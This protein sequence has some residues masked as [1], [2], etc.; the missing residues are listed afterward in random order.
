MFMQDVTRFAA[1]PVTAAAMLG[2]GLIDG[3]LI[4]TAAG[5]RPVQSLRVGDSLQT[6]DGG[7]RRVVALNRREVLPG[8]PVVHLS[9]GHFDACS[10]VM[11]MPGQ[12]V[13]LDTVGLM[14]A[15]YARIAAA[16]LTACVGASTATAP[17]RVE[18]VTPIFAEEEVVWA[19]SGLLL[20]CPGLRG[21]DTA[22]PEL[23]ARA[24]TLFLAERSRRFA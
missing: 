19:Q 2:Q 8:E 24:A 6:L 9:G 12:S 14:A 4:E 10:D 21:G 18:V 22:F 15:P 5:W 16:A 11:L 1:T 13:L 3:T 7:L 20:L 23:H 17:R